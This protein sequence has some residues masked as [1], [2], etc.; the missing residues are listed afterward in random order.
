MAEFHIMAMPIHA[1][2]HILLL[3]L[4]FQLCIPHHVG[5]HVNEKQVLLQIKSTWGS[6]TALASWYLT[7][8][9]TSSHCSWAFIS[10]DG[11]GRVISLSLP[12]ITVSGP[13]PDAIGELRS[14]G[15]C[16]S[17]RTSPTSPSTK[18][19]HRRGAAGVLAA[20]E[21]KPSRRRSES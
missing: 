12:N 18:R 16:R 13:V 20:Q 1:Y 8:S 14:H 17:S 10:C 11:A 2:L 4:V 5:A 7:S 19:L 9:N 15:H 3:C 21:P 6:P